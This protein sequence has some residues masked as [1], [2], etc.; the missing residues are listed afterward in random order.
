LQGRAL[1]NA[2]G[3]LFVACRDHVVSLDAGRDGKT[4]DSITTGAGLDNFDYSTTQ[5]FFT[6]QRLWPGP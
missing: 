2:R 3:F 5:N 4:T 6:P 1:D